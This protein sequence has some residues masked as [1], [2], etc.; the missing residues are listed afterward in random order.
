VVS[1]RLPKSSDRF[2]SK[3]EGA[4]LS[5]SKKRKQQQA[6]ANA[7][8]RTRSGRAYEAPEDSDDSS[9]ASSTRLKTRSLKR[10]RGRPSLAKTVQTKQAKMAAKKKAARR[11]QDESDFET[12][13][14]DD[15]SDPDPRILKRRRRR[16]ASTSSLSS[17]S[18]SESDLTDIS[19]LED[20]VDLHGVEVDAETG[21]AIN[22]LTGETT[23]LEPTSANTTLLASS[24]PVIDEG[25]TSLSATPAEGQTSSWSTASVLKSAADSINK[26]ITI[27]SPKRQHLPQSL[28]LSPRTE[29]SDGM[30]SYQHDE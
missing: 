18:A 13:S 7:K 3:G 26:M 2:N 5:P 29:T 6:A 27:V 15:D 25:P 4:F 20:S 14:D 23:T 8:G 11:G 28:P 19:D 22:P 17:L 16:Q 1:A 30:S 24:I 9:N 21:T 12:D 10:E